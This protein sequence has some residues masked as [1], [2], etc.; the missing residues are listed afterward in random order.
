MGVDRICERLRHRPRIRF[1]RLS[2]LDLAVGVVVVA[3]PGQGGG[4]SSLNSCFFRAVEDDERAGDA[5]G[6]SIVSMSVI[7]TDRLAAVA[8]FG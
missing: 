6:V 1:C 2:S 8:G 5:E 3:R 7:V 4:R